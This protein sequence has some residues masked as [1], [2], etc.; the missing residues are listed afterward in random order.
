MAKAPKKSESAKS[1][2]AVPAG[3]RPATPWDEMDR[4]FDQLMSQGWMRPRFDWPAWAEARLPA[5]MRAPKVDVID[6]DTELVLKAELPGVDKKDLEVTMSDDSVTIKGSSS[7]EEKEEKGDYHR[8]EITRGSFS[9]TVPLPCQ[10]DTSKTQ[11]S[12]KDGMLELTMPKASQAKRKRV[13]VR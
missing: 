1:Q 4:W 8:S 9:R 13:D 10:V 6:R 5:G 11:A 7:H 12:F 2:A 3:R